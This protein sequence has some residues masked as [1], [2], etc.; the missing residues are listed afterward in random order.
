MAAIA[1]MAG[2]P[3][4]YVLEKIGAKLRVQY[5]PVLDEPLPEDLQRLVDRLR[6]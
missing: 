1:F 3:T 5:A 2:W 6:G 4:A